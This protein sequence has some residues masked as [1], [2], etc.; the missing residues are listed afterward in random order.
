MTRIL[1]IGGIRWI[2]IGSIPSWEWPPSL[3]FHSPQE[4][5]A[6]PGDTRDYSGDWECLRKRAKQ[7]SRKV[8]SDVW[9][10]SEKRVQQDGTAPKVGYIYVSGLTAARQRSSSVAVSIDLKSHFGPI[11]VDDLAR[12]IHLTVDKLPFLHS[13]EI[14]PVFNFCTSIEE[15]LIDIVEATAIAYAYDGEIQSTAP[16]NAFTP[17]MNTSIEDADC[18]RAKQS[19]GWYPQ[20]LEGFVRGMD[21][22]ATALEVKLPF[23]CTSKRAVI[24]I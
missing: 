2:S 9:S 20:R 22:Y 24:S 10:L 13:S 5:G 19:L 7:D 16:Y 4:C 21:V 8:F 15:K 1:I 3:Q 6:D 18:S 11:H 17:T 12:G 23:D 14:Y